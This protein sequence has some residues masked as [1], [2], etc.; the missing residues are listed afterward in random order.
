VDSVIDLSRLLGQLPIEYLAII[1]A[2]AGLALAGF[3]IH[4][5]YS[6][7]KHKDRP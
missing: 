5:V 6:I 7:A 2:L 4:A 1:V 3:A